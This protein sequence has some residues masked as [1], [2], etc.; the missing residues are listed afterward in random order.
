MA[1]TATGDRGSLD[2]VML[3]MDVV[4]TLRHNERLVERE[5]STEDRE[6]A[7]LKR[8]REIYTAQG[9]EVSYAVL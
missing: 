9:I 7:L 3:A 5:L 2:D 8:L 4:D 1:D 6:Q